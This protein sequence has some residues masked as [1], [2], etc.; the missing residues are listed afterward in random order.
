M[1]AY[2]SEVVYMKPYAKDKT[3]FKMF[4]FS[5]S[6]EGYFEPLSNIDQK[7]YLR[8]GLRVNLAYS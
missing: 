7:P 6:R 4:A 5:N 8:I 3:E 1:L 2:T